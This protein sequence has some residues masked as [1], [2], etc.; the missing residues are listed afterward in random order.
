MFPL[1]DCQTNLISSEQRAAKTKTV[2]NDDKALT[3]EKATFE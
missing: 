3:R 1:P 2:L